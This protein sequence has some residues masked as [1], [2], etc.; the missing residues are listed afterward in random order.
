MSARYTNYGPALVEAGYDITPVKGKAAYLPGWTDRPAEALDYKAHADASIGVLTGGAHNLVAVDIDVLDPFTE[1][2]IETLIS[3]ELGEAPRR[4][5]NAPK[6]LFLFR[7]TQPFLKTRTGVYDIDGDDSAVE[8]LGEGQ[9]FVASGI[10]PDTHQLYRW[11]DDRLIDLTP[12]ELTAVTPEQLHTFLDGCR[13]ILGRVGTLKGRV[14]ERKPAVNGTSLMLKELDGEMR[15][16]DAALAFLPNDDEHYDD[17]VAT[18]HAIKGALGDDGRE[19]AHRWSKRS[20]KYD[21]AETDRAWDSIKNVKHIGA[22]SIYHWAQQYGF[23]LRDIRD[24]AKEEVKVEAAQEAVKGRILSLGQLASLPPPS[25]LVDGLI[26]R[27]TLVNVFGPPASFKSFLALDIGLSVAHGGSWHGREVHSGPVLYIAGE[28]AAGIRKRASAWMMNQGVSDNGEPFFVLPQAVNIRDQAEVD[29]L[30]AEAGETMPQQPALVIIDTLARSFGGG[31]ENSNVDMGEFIMQ[32][33]RIKAAFDGA[34]VMIVHHSGKDTT[35][36]ARGHSS[37]Y[38]AVDTELELKRSQ[39]SDSV[40]IRNSKQKDA[41]ETDGIRMT[42]RVV[43]LPPGDGLWLEEETSIVLDYD[44]APEA[45]DRERKL[46]GNQKAVMQQLERAIE[47]VGEARFVDGAERQV[48]TAETA[49]TYAYMV[50]P[51]PE[52]KDNRW[53]NYSRAVTTLRDRGLVGFYNDYFWVNR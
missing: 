41:E 7:C 50:L 5:G 53:T 45:V 43:T 31:D 2:Q 24:E 8:I 16:V 17:W 11:P 12:G 23:N 34:T 10:H 18:L 47:Q 6:S 38:G 32:C 39:G 25:P 40:T 19:L 15:E 9:Q 20:E 29:A 37:L 36:G 51:K 52:G 4:V 1:G 22:G 27:N 21:E 44:E 30:I 48:I 42:A 3:D 35:R 49:K 26:F 13:N 33:D 28:G 14:S 46:G